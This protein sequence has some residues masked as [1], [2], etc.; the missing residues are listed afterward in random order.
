MDIPESAVDSFKRAVW[1]IIE[2]NPEALTPYILSHTQALKRIV[3]RGVEC[4]TA[5]D[6]GA[7]DGRWTTLARKA[8][9]DARYHLIEAFRQ[10]EPALTAFCG[11]D[12][13]LSFT[14]AAAGEADGTTPF[15]NSVEEPFGGSAM[16]GAGEPQWIV[17]QVAIDCEVER[18]GLAGPF[19]IKLD[20]HGTEREI[21][22]GAEKTLEQTS[23]LVIE[24]YNFGDDARRFP[25]MCQHVESLGFHCIDIGEPMFRDRDRDR[26]FW[27]IDFF[28]VRK[29]RP[30]ALHSTF[31]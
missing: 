8:W 16:P 17:P 26:A 10:W 12:P 27:Q 19:L 24:M 18:L 2:A 7:S 14:L 28:F 23:V 25:A 20:T 15:S 4:R 11:D 1:R 13:R 5:I 6:V 31:A 21:L 3:G 22:A 29:D 30:E 9:P